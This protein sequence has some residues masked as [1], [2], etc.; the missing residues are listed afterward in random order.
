MP[1]F[2][3]ACFCKRCGRKVIARRVLVCDEYRWRFRVGLVEVT[4]CPGCG[5]KLTGSS[6]T[7]QQKSTAGASTPTA[8]TGKRVH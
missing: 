8:L 4:R 7:S 6:T 5:E 1:A 3:G 2:S